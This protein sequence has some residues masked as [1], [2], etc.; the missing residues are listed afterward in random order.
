MGKSYKKNRR[1]LDEAVCDATIFVS[2]SDIY[3]ADS[4]W[5]K[6][7]D[8]DGGQIEEMRAQFEDGAEMVRV[9]LRPRFGGGYNIE[10]G[11]HRVIAAKLADVGF[12]EAI[13]V[14]S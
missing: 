6:L 13:I 10:D 9:V 11:R 5:E 8:R 7:L 4:T 3:M 2:L 14:G 12:I 1:G